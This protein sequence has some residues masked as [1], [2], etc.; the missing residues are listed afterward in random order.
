MSGMKQ[1]I[2]CLPQ[3]VGL[4]AGGIK[5]IVGLVVIVGWHLHR[6][7]LIQ[8]PL[9]FSILCY[10]TAMV[11]FLSGLTLLTLANRIDQLLQDDRISCRYFSSTVLP[12]GLE[13]LIQYFFIQINRPLPGHLIPSTAQVLMSV[14]FPL[15]VIT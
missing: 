11:C 10:D 14:G 3:V 5:T 8:V 15:E 6:I 13:P 9:G 1:V 12:Y 2:P 7:K 4:T